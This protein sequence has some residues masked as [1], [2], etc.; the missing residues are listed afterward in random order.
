MTSISASPPLQVATPVNL[1]RLEHIVQPVFLMVQKLILAEG[2]A[3][4]YL[5]VCVYQSVVAKGLFI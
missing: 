2:V 4:G 1:K 3:S 5:K